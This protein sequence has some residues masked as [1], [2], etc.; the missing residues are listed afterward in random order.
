VRKNTF[1]YPFLVLALLASASYAEET[2][3][4]DG[5]IREHVTVIGQAASIDK[6]L[7]EQR[8]SDSI[9]SVVHADGV[10]QLPDDNA[11]EALQRMPG[12][13][14]ERDQGEGRYV[15]VR[16]LGADLN[17]VSINGS[18]L[19]SP[20]ADV[21]AVAMDVL[22]SELIQSL[23]VTKTLTPDMEANSLGGTIEVH[24]LS[25]FDHENPFH[26][27]SL[28]GNYD[29]NTD[30]TSPK[31]SGAITR[32]FSVG[33][34]TENFGVALAA[35]WQQ[36]DFGSENVE[37]GGAWDGTN[38][39]EVELRDYTLARERTGLGLNF[40]FKPDD[41]TS[42]YLRTLYSSFEDT[43][44]RLANIFE[45][46][47]GAVPAN[48]NGTWEGIR[49]FKNRTE[50]QEVHSVVLGAEKLLETWT[51]KGQ[52]GYSHAFQDTP[53]EIEGVF[54]G[55]SGVYN[56]IFTSTRKPVLTM[57]NLFY[58]SGEF[59]LVE[60]AI[61]DQLTTDTEYNL[62][63]DLAHD[64]T[65]AD[66]PSQLKFGG[67]VSRREKDNDIEVTEYEDFGAADTSLATLG[68]G[69]VDYGLGR[70]GPGINTNA[71]RDIVSGLTTGERND[72]DSRIED[73]R[74]ME[75]IDALYVM[76]TI[77]IEDLRLIA[78]VRYEGTSFESRGTGYEVDALGDG[79]F[80]SRSTDKSYD[81]F[82]PGLHAQYQL[83]RSTLLRGAWT[84]SVVRPTF[85]Q[86]MPGFVTNL[87]DLEAEFGNPDL[88]PL[89]SSNLDFGFERYMGRVGMVSAYAFYKD[90]E[91]FI[92]GT[93]LAGF[94]DWA[95]YDEAATFANGKDASIY[96]LELAWSQKFGNFIAGA[97]LTI[98]ESKAIIDGYDGGS[99]VKRSIDLPNHSDRVANVMI[100]WEND[101]LSVRLAGNYKS[102]YLV[103]ANP[104]DS[105]DEDLYADEQLFVDFVANYYINERLKLS[106]DAI[107]LGD[108]VFYTYV[109]RESLNAQYEEYGPAYKLGITMTG[110]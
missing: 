18:T 82:L 58:D 43:E 19:P 25:A 76:N 5:G 46:D 67:K 106:F 29:T 1:H 28:E 4:E 32:K 21:R 93:D 91:N 34:G 97:N 13:S 30:Q 31:L 108:E 41:M 64:Y 61:A 107:N 45:E 65:W 10:A 81:H 95:A 73:F 63:L 79:Q 38:L 75:D 72:E 50:T 15:S 49:E 48:V 8:R 23:T 59:D 42:Y 96:G 26:T 60:A 105:A 89:E 99:Y 47:A 98:S 44:T 22:P 14:V 52:L 9:S 85:G 80:I 69:N 40:D 36:R 71:I 92:Y 7:K 27:V 101:R 53:N 84:N 70:F 17:S 88:D 16:G 33:D 74:M 110:F 12:V 57:E 56:G 68:A 35:S 86:L 3:Q 90:I 62:K 55:D 77:D 37:T 78:G 6:A 94:G 104:L 39:E 2:N 20:E 102:D 11:A 51:V 100:G 87:E 109:G 83:G 24:T 103:E 54:E 66:K